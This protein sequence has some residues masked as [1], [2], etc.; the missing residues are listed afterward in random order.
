MKRSYPERRRCDKE[1]KVLLAPIQYTDIENHIMTSVC[2][3]L[4]TH[5]SAETVC[6]YASPYCRVPDRF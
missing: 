3:K 5:H 2:A 1:K 4:K 6:R